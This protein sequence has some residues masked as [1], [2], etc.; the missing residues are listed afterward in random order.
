MNHGTNGQPK[1][2]EAKIL[3]I[4]DKLSILSI[5][6]LKLLFKQKEI[7]LNDIEFV[8]NLEGTTS[9]YWLNCVLLKDRNE[10]DAFL[11]Y[12]NENGVMT[13]PAWTLMTKL[14]MYE[15]CIKGSIDNALEM[16]D[17]LVNIPSSVL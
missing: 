9:N 5:P 1:S 4:A 11:K 8:K 10:R 2:P 12:S 17:R 16:E 13:R 15:H 6:V 7:T 3:Q 14:P